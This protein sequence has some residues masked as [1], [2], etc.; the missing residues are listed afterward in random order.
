MYRT[1]FL[2]VYF[3]ISMPMAIAQVAPPATNNQI[4]EHRLQHLN[5]TAGFSCQNPPPAV[6]SSAPGKYCGG[7]SP[8][9]VGHP[10]DLNAECKSLYGATASAST[11][12]PDAY[13]WVCQK[14][15]AADQGLDMQKACGHQYGANA[16][17]TVVGIDA[18]DW[19]CLKPA[20]VSGHVVPVL[21]FPVEKLDINNEVFVKTALQRLESLLGGIRMF[22]EGKTTG[23]VRGTNAFV[24]LTNA[25]AMDWQC[26]ALTTDNV[27]PIC[28]YNPIFNQINRDGLHNRVKQELA[29]GRWNVLAENSSV[30]IGGFP[31][32]GPSPSTT[33]TWCGAEADFGGSYFSQ[34]PL[35]SYAS[36]STTA[37]NPPEYE[38][39][40][41][42][43][44]HEFG[45]TMGLPH[46]DDLSYYFTD[47]LHP[48]LSHCT[49][50]PKPTNYSHS[51]MYQGKGTDS[52]FFPFEA[53]RLLRFLTS[54]Q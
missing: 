34:A 10:I 36:C 16:I 9:Q 1:V 43:A 28:N 11:V 20:D 35:D 23:A 51:I 13:G 12:R 21:L 54:W 14:P 15:G 17:A 5:A 25:S 3:S 32:L 7:E 33:A 50:G 24:Q 46:T 52:L 6:S 31:T 39:A 42:S 40:F 26:F 37:N 47:P 44:G 48:E 38:N 19:R 53:C 45:H 2:I 18:T 22:Y 8:I 30:R 4:D 41:Y 27:Y 49:C 29:N